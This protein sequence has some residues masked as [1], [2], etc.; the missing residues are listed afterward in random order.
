MSGIM[1]WTTSAS[2]SPS[3][4]NFFLW[5]YDWQRSSS[6]DYTHMLRG[7]FLFHHWMAGNLRVKPS[8]KK[9][10]K[11]NSKSVWWLIQLYF[12]V[13]LSFS[14]S[15]T[16]SLPKAVIHKE[17]GSSSTQKKELM[18]SGVEVFRF[19]F[20]AIKNEERCHLPK[21]SGQWNCLTNIF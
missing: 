6:F 1:C 16:C 9:A 5:T 20:H 8:G 13:L 12:A 18:S 2:V 17:P 10:V 14:K 3:I 11:T 19:I 15:I 4:M 21:Q 7:L